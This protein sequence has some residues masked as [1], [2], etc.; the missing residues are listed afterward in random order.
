MRL[1]INVILFVVTL[2]LIFI[3]WKSIQEPIAFKAE[4]DKRKSAVVA[5]LIKNRDAQ[6][7]YRNLTGE[8]APNYDTLKQVIMNDSFEIVS[9]IGDIDAGEDIQRKVTK[10]S[11]KDS[12]IGGMGINLDSIKYI[13]YTDGKEFVL[14]ADTLTYQK[15]NVPVI[16]V[17]ASYLDF[18]SEYNSDRFKRYDSRFAKI[19][20]EG[21]PLKY[22]DRAKPTTSGNWEN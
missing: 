18:M 20:D 7:A 6:I 2:V 5:Q 9:I 17:S 21:I 15:I 8:F 16:E 12:I 3:L 11:A 4:F 14:F 10:I 13:P 1:I 19:L 22:G